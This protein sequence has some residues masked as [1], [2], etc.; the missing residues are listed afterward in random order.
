MK[1][2]IFLVTTLNSGGIENYLL[3]FLNFFDGQIE[4]IIICKGNVFGELEEEYQKIKHIQLIKMD[5][6]FFN[7]NS[8]LKL[9][10]FFK[11]SKVNSVC[12][13]TGNFAGLILLSANFAGI[14]NRISFYRGSTNHFSETKGRMI[15]NHLMLQL[16]KRYACKILS[17]SKSALDYFYS[18][19]DKNDERFKV[20]YNGI[21]AVKFNSSL[22]KLKKEDFEIPS[23]GFVIGHTGRCNAAKNHDT[24]IKVAEKICEKYDNIYFVFCGKDTDVFLLE[25]IL[26][27]IIL[28]DKVKLL[29]YRNDVQNI[30]SIFD[31]YFFP[32]ITEGQPNSLIEAM[33]SGLPIIASNIGP[34]I[35]TTPTI[36][37]DEL[38]S[39]IDV[40]GFF[41]RIEEYYLSRQKREE[42]NFSSWAKKQFAPEVLFNQF[43]KEL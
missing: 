24:I 11:R 28:K 27:N 5:V 38:I 34:I 2:V 4:P 26:N 39:P 25:R 37:H 41:V 43:Y 14:N 32:S 40:D 35:E 29:G 23:N 18:D 22:A 6:G 13:F 12:D 19:R 33:I 8:Y 16:V 1:K 21:D 3:R 42:N 30:L 31:L 10:S 20:I 36:L 9:Y 17:N 15:Y 7:L